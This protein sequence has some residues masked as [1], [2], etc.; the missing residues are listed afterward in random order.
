MTRHEII[1]Q[2]LKI[3]MGTI[4]IFGLLYTIGLLRSIDNNIKIIANESNT[5]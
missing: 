3:L 4:A 1:I 2:W 5:H